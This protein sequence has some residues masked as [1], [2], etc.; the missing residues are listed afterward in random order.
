MHEAHLVWLKDKGNPAAKSVYCKL[1]QEAQVK[2]RAMK[3]MWWMRKAGELQA[4]ADKHNMKLFHDG[5]KAIY[6]PRD[7]ISFPIRTADGTALLSD[8]T[9]VLQRWAQHFETVLNQPSAFDDSVI[10]ELPQWS[11]APHLDDPPT[12]EEVQRAINQTS[13][14]KAPG[15]D[16][17]PAE[18]Y[19]EGG[20]Q[21]TRHLT[22]LF[23]KIWEVEEVPQD[24]KDALIVH[25][26]KRKGDRAYCDEHHGI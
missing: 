5:L 22:D 18:I 11:A 9:D 2:L 21:L 4:A 25:I 26:F 3:D 24:F 7:A 8:R 6:G 20:T 15:A 17:L 19:K 16:A 10:N 12:A 23:T 14:G 13:S 1:R